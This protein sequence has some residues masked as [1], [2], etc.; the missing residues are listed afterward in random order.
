[1]TEF[2]RRW[3]IS[4]STWFRDYVYIPLGGNRV[5][6]TNWLRNIFIVWALTGL[7]HGAAWNFVFWGLFFGVLLVMN[8][9]S[10]STSSA[11]CHLWA[12]SMPCS[13]P[14]WLGPVSQRVPVP[15]EELPQAMLGFHGTNPSAIWSRTTCFTCCR[16]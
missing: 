7:W 14:G 13:G 3:H 5:S 4:L 9:C 10:C 16:S 12:M 8:G 15:G 1:V 6:A 11:G 2:W